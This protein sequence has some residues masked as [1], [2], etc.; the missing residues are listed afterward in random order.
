[1]KEHLDEGIRTK[2]PRGKDKAKE[3]FARNGKVSSKHLR[4]LER[5]ERDKRKSHT[6]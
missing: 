1:M 5:R 4:E 6:R 2:R 3:R